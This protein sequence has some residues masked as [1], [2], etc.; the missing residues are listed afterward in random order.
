MDCSEALLKYVINY[1]LEH[2]KEELEFLNENVDNTL[3]DRLKATAGEEFAHVTYTEAIDI[4]EKATDVEF[5]VKPYWGLDLD[6]EHE[7]Y[8]SEQVYKKPVF[9]TDYPKDFKAFYMRA[10]D[11]GKTVAAADLLVPEIGELIGG[12]QREERLD[13]LEARMA[14]LDMNEEDYKWYLELRKYGGTVHSGFGIGFER[15]VMYITGME[16]I[17]DVIAYPRTPGN[18]EF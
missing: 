18:A 6:S 16:N 5:E 1:V 2:A 13:K 11:D 14:E 8:L 9:I 12:S 7:R 10:N 15:L 4:L 3:I 17:R